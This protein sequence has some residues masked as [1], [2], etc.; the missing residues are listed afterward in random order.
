MR[1]ECI[2]N[3]DKGDMTGTI[4]TRNSGLPGAYGV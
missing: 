2:N 4:D 1:N 3:I